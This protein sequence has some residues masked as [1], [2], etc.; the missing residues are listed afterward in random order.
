MTWSRV[1]RVSQRIDRRFR[2]SPDAA[3]QARTALEKLGNLP[4]A[5]LEDIKL[6][7]SELVTNSVRHAGLPPNGT[8]GLVVEVLPVVVRVVVADTGPGFEPHHA[9]PSIFQTSGWGLYIVEQIADRWGVDR[10]GGTHV[11]FEFDRLSAT[12]AFSRCA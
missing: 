3:K 11:W 10:N 6:L 12:G 9:H 1:V 4:S 7:V 5:C 8:I 2:A